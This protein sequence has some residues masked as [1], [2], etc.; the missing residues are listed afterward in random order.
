MI[1][2]KIQIAAMWIFLA[3]LILILGMLDIVTRG[4]SRNWLL[5]G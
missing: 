2:R 1:F 5:R 4:R 3:P